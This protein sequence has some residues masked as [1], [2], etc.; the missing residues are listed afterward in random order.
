MLS[1]AIGRA[2]ADRLP[3]VLET[4]VARNVGL[5]ERF[6]FR[7]FLA[8]DAPDGGPSLWFMGRDPGAAG[9]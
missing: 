9:R 4:A 6:G 2:E 3:L 8:A 5:Y 1:C 7:V